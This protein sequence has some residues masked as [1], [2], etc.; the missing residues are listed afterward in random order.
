LSAVRVNPSTVV[1]LGST[2]VLASVP[3]FVETEPVSLTDATGEI[4][5]RL[6]LLIPENATVLEG[7]MVDMTAT[8]T[9]IEGG[10]TVRQEPV[11]QGLGP[12]LSADVALDRVDVILSGSLPLLESLGPDDIFVILDLTGLLPGNHVLTPR[13]VVPN[14]IRAESVLPETVEVVIRPAPELSP[15]LPPGQFPTG[16]VP[17]TEA[18]TAAVTLTTPQPVGIPTSGPRPT[19]LP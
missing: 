7:N 15:L 19:D 12:G 2:D 10:A 5:R 6:Q 8:I 13:V 16:T 3:G 1:L 9:P 18:I 17:P 4:Q 11:L 14:G